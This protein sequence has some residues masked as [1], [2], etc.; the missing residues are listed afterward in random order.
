MQ[1]ENKEERYDADGH[2]HSAVGGEEC[3]TQKHGRGIW[4]VALYLCGMEGFAP[5]EEPEIARVTFER[6]GCDGEEWIYESGDR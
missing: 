3:V 6:V 5:D 2:W 1:T 4:I